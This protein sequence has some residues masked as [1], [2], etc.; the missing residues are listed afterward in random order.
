MNTTFTRRHTR[1]RAGLEQV[2]RSPLQ[3]KIYW[4]LSKLLGTSKDSK[5]K[6]KLIYYFR[7]RKI[8][9]AY[10]FCRGQISQQKILVD[11]FL[12]NGPENLVGIPSGKNLS[13]EIYL[14][15]NFPLVINPHG[16]ILQPNTHN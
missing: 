16:C 3:R 14:G 12:Q 5:Y 9:V 4:L 10:K 11:F 7:G 15:R 6:I 1:R 2:T 13:T 8:F